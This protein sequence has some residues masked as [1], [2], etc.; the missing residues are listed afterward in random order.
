[1]PWR[2]HSADIWH[3]P[4]PGKVSMTS[5]KGEHRAFIAIVANG[6]SLDYNAPC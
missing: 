3:Q 2:Q 6:S 5:V 1:M 4:S